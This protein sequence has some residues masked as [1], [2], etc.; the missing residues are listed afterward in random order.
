M[1]S[2]CGQVLKAVTCKQF[3][4]YSYQVKTLRLWY[5]KVS[6]A[7]LGDASLGFSELG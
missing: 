2:P 3:P 5:A 6:T 1:V 4:F 7:G